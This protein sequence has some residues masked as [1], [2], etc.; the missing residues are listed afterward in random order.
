MRF[1]L[2]QEIQ[3]GCHLEI[4]TFFPHIPPLPF[5]ASSFFSSGPG[6]LDRANEIPG[7]GPLV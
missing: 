4:V 2:S 3:D 7:G 1:L 6:G 5:Q